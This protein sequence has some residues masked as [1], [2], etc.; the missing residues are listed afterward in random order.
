MFVKKHGISP[1]FFD[2]FLITV[3][4]ELDSVCK[5]VSLLRALS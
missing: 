5:V 3:R 1:F 4:V 2:P